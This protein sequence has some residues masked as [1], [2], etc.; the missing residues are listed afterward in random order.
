MSCKHWNE[1]GNCLECARERGQH[2]AS[3][4]FL[5]LASAVNKDSQPKSATDPTVIVSLAWYVKVRS[6]AQ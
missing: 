6:L 1:P 4:A 3:G 2:E 5:D